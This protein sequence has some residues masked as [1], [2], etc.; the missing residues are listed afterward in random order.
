[1]KK[2]PTYEAAY[3]E[4][5]DIVSDIEQE[6]ISVDTITLK[7]KR[8]MELISFCREKLLKAGKEMHE[9]LKENEN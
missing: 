6:N 7:I 9:A 2:E 8:A 5:K 3:N 1:M 4:L